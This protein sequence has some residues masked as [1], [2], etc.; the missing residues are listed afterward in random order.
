[1]KS[2]RLFITALFV[3]ALSAL[4]FVPVRAE[5]NPARPEPSAAVPA[6]PDKTELK[7]ELAAME[8]AFCAM[9]KSQ[10]LLAAFKYFA[11]PDVSFIDTDP[12]KWRGLPA[13][14]ERIGPDVPGESLTW[15][16]YCTD[17]SDDGTMGFNYGRYEARTP[18][19][20]GKVS[21]HT[22][23]FLTIWKRQ[24][25]GSWKYVMD[26]G[27]PDRSAPNPATTAAGKPAGS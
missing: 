3:T 19:P 5:E 9:G 21:V 12:R 11:A 14:V 20:G 10:G 4:L 15:S 1:M 17:V 25:D 7:K 13:V 2:P 16:A 8:D 23:W 22:G 27:A 26:N 6:K 18:G 24:P